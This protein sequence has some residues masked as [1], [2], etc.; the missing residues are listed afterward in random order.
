MTGHQGS[1]HD[2]GQCAKY[3]VR[4]GS[5]CRRWRIGHSGQLVAWRSRHPSCRYGISETIPVG[6]VFAQAPSGRRSAT[7]AYILGGPGY[8][9][10]MA[11]RGASGAAD[12]QHRFRMAGILCG[13]HCSR[14][15]AGVSCLCCGRAG[16]CR[17][18]SQ[19]NKDS[20]AYLNGSR[21]TTEPCRRPRPRTTSPP[22]LASPMRGRTGVNA[23]RRPTKSA[24][25]PVDGTA[26]LVELPS[27]A[28]N[29]VAIT[30][31]GQA[32]SPSSVTVR[33]TGYGSP[34]CGASSSPQS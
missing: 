21:R 6:A 28:S 20:R 29:R 7:A 25:E 22:R 16:A 12:S 9:V 32:A 24:E 2:R 11:A 13:V 34:S 4:Q 30:W 27:A 18:Y 23:C 33:M 10:R 19:A 8:R 26:M 1:K 15:Q 17:R 14:S 5:A 31:S 3:L